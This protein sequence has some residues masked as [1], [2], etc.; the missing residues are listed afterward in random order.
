MVRR[1]TIVKTSRESFVLA[2]DYE[3]AKFEREELAFQKAD[4]EERAAQLG[5]PLTKGQKLPAVGI[6]EHQ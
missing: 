2:A 1:T 6:Y 3:F 5:L 4:R